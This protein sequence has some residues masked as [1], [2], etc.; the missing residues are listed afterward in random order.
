MTL[1]GLTIFHLTPSLYYILSLGRGES[2]ILL[3]PLRNLSG[4]RV[5]CHSPSFSVI[6]AQWLVQDL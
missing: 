3:N 4:H 1:A 5:G 6:D 2:T